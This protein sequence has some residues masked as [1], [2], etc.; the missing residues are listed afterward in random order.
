MD[1]YTPQELSNLENEEIK[2]LFLEVRSRLISKEN[3]EEKKSLEI[4]YC[5]IAREL[6]SRIL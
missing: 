1:E 6:E 3:I 4:Y 5:Y 2:K